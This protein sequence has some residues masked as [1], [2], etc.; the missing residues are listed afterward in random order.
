MARMGRNR[1]IKIVTSF[2]MTVV[3]VLSLFAGMGAIWVREESHSVAAGDDT[4]GVSYA[5]H[6][7]SLTAADKTKELGSDENPYTVLEIVPDANMAQFG[8]LVGGQE[9]IDIAALSANPEDLARYKSTLSNYLDVTEVNEA[10]ALKEFINLLNANVSNADYELYNAEGAEKGEVTAHLGDTGLT[11]VAVD[12]P[13]TQY[14]T[15]TK[16]EGD[17]GDYKLIE[18]E[19]E[20][21]LRYIF[22]L[23]DEVPATGKLYIDND[24]DK[25]YMDDAGNTEVA[26]ASLLDGHKYESKAEAE[27]KGQE[28]QATSTTAREYIFSSNAS[29]AGL[30]KKVTQ[31]S[32]EYSGTLFQKGAALSGEYSL[33]YMLYSGGNR[34]IKPNYYFTS[35][36]TATRANNKY[37]YYVTFEL[38]EA[39]Y[40]GTLYKLSDYSNESSLKRYYKSN[41]QTDT[42]K[43]DFFRTEKVD[44]RTDGNVGLIKDKLKSAIDDGHSTP[45]SVTVSTAE[46]TI[47]Y[48]RVPNS[49]PW[50]S[51]T[52]D[53]FNQLGSVWIENDDT[54]WLFGTWG[55][56]S[57]YKY[58]DNYLYHYY[59]N[60]TNESGFLR[61]YQYK[62]DVFGKKYYNLIIDTPKNDA[63]HYAA[64]FQKA[65]ISDGGRYKVKSVSASGSDNIMSYRKVSLSDDFI[66]KWDKVSTGTGD[67][68]KISTSD[69]SIPQ[70]VGTRDDIDEEPVMLGEYSAHPYTVPI[71]GTDTGLS[72][73][74]S[75]DYE[76]YILVPIYDLYEETRYQYSI[77]PS[78][79]TPA[80]FETAIA[81]YNWSGLRYFESKALGED[82]DQR[83]Q[84]LTDTAFLDK[85]FSTERHTAPDEMK[86]SQSQSYKLGYFPEYTNK[87]LFKKYA[88]GLAYQSENSKNDEDA[89][90][91]KFV[92]WYTDRYGVNAY[93]ESAGVT[94][95]LTL[96]AK[97]LTTY[98]SDNKEVVVDGE[99]TIVKWTGYK[100]TFNANIKNPDTE[101]Q[102]KLQGM[103]DINMPGTL[104]TDEDD[105]A[106]KYTSY[107]GSLNKGA[108]IIEPDAIPVRPNKLFDGWYTKENP[109]SGDKPFFDEN[110]GLSPEI[111]GDVTLYAKW[112]DVNDTRYSFELDVNQSSLPAGVTGSIPGSKII[113]SVAENGRRYYPKDGGGQEKFETV[114]YGN[115]VASNSR[116]VFAGW[117]LDQ[118]CEIKFEFDTKSI[119]L[120]ATVKEALLEIDPTL[121]HIPLYAKWVDTSVKPIYTV[122]FVGN[123]P[124][125]AFADVQG[126]T[127]N[128]TRVR[129]MEPIANGT[130]TPVRPTL[131]GNVTAKIAAYKVR[132]V[133]VT[134]ADLESNIGLIDAANLIVINET[135]EADMKTLCHAYHKNDAW[136]TDRHNA[137]KDVTS[138][139]QN[140]ISWAVAEKLLNR[141]AGIKWNSAAGR[142]DSVDTCPVMFDYHIY[143]SCTS[144]S[145]TLKKTVKF[146]SRYSGATTDTDILGSSGATGYK[147]NI[148]KIYLMTQIASPVAVYNAFF[149]GRYMKKIEG[150]KLSTR[151]SEKYVFSPDTNASYSGADEYWNEKTLIPYNILESSDW[152]DTNRAGTAAKLGLAT[153]VSKTTSTISNRML[154]FKNTGSGKNFVNEFAKPLMNG[155][156]TIN[157]FMLGEEHASDT[158][159]YK[160]QD[161][162]YYM[163]HDTESFMNLNRDINVLEIQPAT[164]AHADEYWLWY[165]G[166]YAPNITGKISGTAMSS[167]EFQC[168]IE[169]LNSK[170]DV[171]YMGTKTKVMNLDGVEDTTSLDW[172]RPLVATNTRLVYYHTGN[173][174]GFNTSDSNNDKLKTNYYK[175][176]TF[177]TV[178]KKGEIVKNSNDITNDD[179]TTV[180]ASSGNDFSFAKYKA[181]AEFLNSGYPIIFDSG[182]FETGTNTINTKKIDNASW[183]YKMAKEVTTAG[184]GY[185]WF[186]EEVGNDPATNRNFLIALMNKTFS[187]VIDSQPTEYRDRTVDAYKTYTDDRVYIN[188]ASDN[189]NTN[190]DKKVLKYTIHIDS[191]LPDDTFKIRM[192][193]DTNAD[194]KYDEDTEELDNI[195]VYDTVAKR[196]ENSGTARLEP[197]RTYE[198]TRTI[199]DYA[200][201]IP[202]KL[203]IISRTKEGVRVEKTG[204]SAVKVKSDKKEKL[205][206]LQITTDLRDAANY[207]KIL[208]SD[209]KGNRMYTPYLSQNMNH[210]YFDI[211]STIYLPTDE[212]IL[213]AYNSKPAGSKEISRSN[214][215]S[216]FGNGSIDIVGDIKYSSG[217]GGTFT[218]F[219]STTNKWYV[220]YPSYDFFN[221]IYDSGD[222]VFSGWNASSFVKYKYENAG[223]FAY[224]AHNLNEFEV[225]FFR[226][227]INTFKNQIANE[228]NRENYSF[229]K[230][231]RWTG[232]GYELEKDSVKWN[233]INML[234]LGFGEGYNDIT[235][236]SSRDLIEKFISS[237]KTVLFTIDTT[238]NIRYSKSS[239]FK[240]LY[241]YY[242]DNPIHGSTIL[243]EHFTGYNITADFAD[244]IGQDRYGAQQNRGYT[245]LPSSLSGSGSVLLGMDSQIKAALGTVDGRNRDFTDINL[246]NAKY[247]SL[248]YD[249]PFKPNSGALKIW[250]SSGKIDT[251]R[252][253]TTSRVY[254]KTNSDE[255]DKTRNKVT[256]DSDKRALV[257][258][259][260]KKSLIKDSSY[261]PVFKAT[262][263]NEGQIA[264]YPFQVSTKTSKSGKK[265][266]DV[267]ASNCPYIQLNMEDDDI[268]VWYSVYQQGSSDFDV[269]NI[270]NDGTNN[271]YIYNKGNVTY[272][273]VGQCQG[274]LKDDEFKL[275]MNTMVA[276]YRASAQ[277][278]EPVIM[279]KDKST[280]NEKDY[281]YVDY[282]ATFAISDDKSKEPIGDGVIPHYIK[283]KSGERKDS[284][285]YLLDASNN[286]VVYYTKR[287]TFSLKNYSILLNKVMTVHYY[288]V[289]HDAKTGVAVTLYDKPLVLQ[290]YRIDQ[291][292]GNGVALTADTSANWTIDST[293]KSKITAGEK[294]NPAFYYNIPEGMTITDQKKC[295]R[296]IAMV[297]VKAGQGVVSSLEEYY[298]DI[299]ISEIYYTHELNLKS[300]DKCPYSYYEM[301]TDATGKVVF[302]KKEV[303]STN[304]NCPTVGNFGLDQT[305]SFE[306]EIQVVMRYGRDQSENPA[307]VGTRG[308]VFLKRGLFTLD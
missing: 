156:S 285:G 111:T 188:G 32:G 208:L 228:T 110:T 91:F 163:I 88:I 50:V 105:N 121:V 283:A 12:T 125:A 137:S 243:S 181:V 2:L 192:F 40:A 36:N 213:A 1:N 259:F 57:R 225:H 239:D 133:T 195:L 251:S 93:D 149:T 179:L 140:D 276:A 219:N 231:Y 205:Y 6:K 264:S 62:C 280:E 141:I 178:N 185:N 39:G 154:I 67:Y 162:F 217:Y 46:G 77:K 267:A 275:F 236:K 297:G 279:N 155:D 301:S 92:G 266:I 182:F 293:T 222:R 186:K 190:I 197:G 72:D 51:A 270:L 199:S 143:E 24:T 117:Y 4:L 29:N 229:G 101:E 238:S 201:L 136:Y 175:V 226:I 256:D 277:A 84:Y 126:L 94:D 307:L 167:L 20:P 42:T 253:A 131:E 118:D 23:E 241:D 223:W 102:T 79:Y 249:I 80:R 234:I 122:E 260:T 216:Y 58:N 81:T 273:G 33:E 245:S 202:W 305:S 34:T 83:E 286:R 204:L 75:K 242:E 11:W 100:V 135:C 90:S 232:S 200:G 76:R 262:Q 43:A 233:D 288:P 183:I 237:G 191:L 61:K 211:K 128:V 252:L 146:K 296:N 209:D 123:K 13:T 99:T 284:E 235:D 250:N 31:G 308:V 287:V 152:N 129:Y 124:A 160:T 218:M 28:L 171:I 5:D 54:W 82:T 272:S 269:C 49:S 161:I 116:Y 3:L 8:Y 303:K 257:Q 304:P 138:F 45:E 193:I 206:I 290:T 168:N 132:V 19:K 298:V 150:G 240:V 18:R 70:F 263:T 97:W 144:S 210:Q 30:Y 107:I 78:S 170:Y 38:A 271:Y 248:K 60:Y 85:E 157:A 306:V 120:A 189:S 74:Y 265:Y 63:D 184:S 44:E 153:S 37:K 55:K 212:E 87:E 207:N 112:K 258:G 302:T 289:I 247:Y 221:Y 255:L 176:G 41:E 300:T 59:Y 47:E 14:G 7:L 130:P 180:A 127:N 113:T 66:W 95:N 227:D 26:T 98:P 172:Y 203:Q 53:E 177:S 299:P 174:S 115:P 35:D 164:F 214:A 71:K 281:L 17:S 73:I 292:T 159:E 187:L 147:N 22:M 21:S 254:R 139:I 16:A 109:G 145:N 56:L 25:L 230:S 194:G 106:D 86:A 196:S 220:D 274:K 215:D 169:D 268:V 96:Y 148:Y 291:E 69:Y 65:T 295:Q 198:I 103:V 278:T 89:E 294:T 15:Y 158:H 64:V 52:N 173:Y 151:N 10:V 282:D 244:S 9:P 114:T 165:I 68:L 166:H 224:Y 27:N 108:Q 134:P 48:T 246:K 119:E 261:T 142:N 104:V